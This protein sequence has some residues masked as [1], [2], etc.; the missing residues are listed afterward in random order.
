MSKSGF[1][2]LYTEGSLHQQILPFLASFLTIVE[3]NKNFFTEKLHCGRFRATE[4]HQTSITIKY[5][6]QIKSR[7]S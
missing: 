5:V 2:T 1:F 3:K 7:Q 6:F 4:R